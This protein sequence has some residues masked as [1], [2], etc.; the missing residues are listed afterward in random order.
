MSIAE[1]LAP[2]PSDEEVARAALRAL[3]NLPAGDG[4]VR[5]QVGD[6]AEIVIPRTALTG[7]TQILSTFAHGEGVTVLPAQAELTTQQAADALRVSR[8]YLIRLLDAGE[9]DYRTIGTH[10]RVR[11]SSLVAY[12]RADADRRRAAADA[13]AAETHDLGFA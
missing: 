11:A 6:G 10:R 12:M 5:L 1:P 8:P 7:L 9:I 2:E 3:S 4:P 13:L